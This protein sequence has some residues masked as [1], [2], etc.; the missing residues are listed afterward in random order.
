MAYRGPVYP[1]LLFGMVLQV[2][3]VCTMPTGPQVHWHVF[4]KLIRVRQNKPSMTADWGYLLTEMENYTI[5]TMSFDHAH[6]ML[7][8]PTPL[9][10]CVV[11]GQRKFCFFDIKTVVVCLSSGNIAQK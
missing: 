11:F 10:P 8:Q 9:Y 3:S 1:Y 5:Q 4:V 2:G 6:Y 7:F